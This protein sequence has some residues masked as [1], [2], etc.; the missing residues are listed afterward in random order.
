MRLGVILDD[1]TLLGAGRRSD[2][3]ELVVMRTTFL[4]PPRT[5]A[6]KR[7]AERVHER[8]RDAEV[9]PY[10]WHYLTH[11]ASDGVVV[12]SNRSLALEPGSF[13]HLRGD[14]IAHAWEISR[15]CA[16][17]FGST[18]VVIRTPPSFSPGGLSRRR[19]TDFVNALAPEH[20][21]LVWEPEGLWSSAE[22]AA[23]AEP[24][25]VEVLAP[26]FAMTGQLLE[27][28]G[29]GW[30]RISGGKDAR[31]RAS[32]AEVL[33]YALAEHEGLTVLFEGPRAYANLRSFASALAL[34]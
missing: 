9:I 17:A 12:G 27:F 28:E 22:A 3:V 24:L 7:M 1:E 30:L 4:N 19:F 14:G 6:A 23:F 18:R 34:V 33:A 26:A 21:R 5:S 15:I 13:G 10:A 29:A 11:E 25:G 20:P 2:P 31:L 16:E 32:H 8:H